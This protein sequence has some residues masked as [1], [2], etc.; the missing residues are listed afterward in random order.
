MLFGLQITQEEDFLGGINYE[1]T[2]D[3]DGLT[4]HIESHDPE[5]VAMML[6]ALED[7][8]TDFPCISC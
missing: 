2:V 6:K 8:D 5:R 4:I 1:S 7:F 3:F